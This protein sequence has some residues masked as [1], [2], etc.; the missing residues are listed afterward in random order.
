MEKIDG[1]SIVLNYVNGAFAAATTR[2]DGH[3]GEDQTE[4][5][6]HIVPNMLNTHESLRVRAEVTLTY[7]TFEALKKI[8]TETNHKNLRNSTVGLLNNKTVYPKKL[9]FL[10]VIGYEIIGSELTREQQLA[11]L[12]MLGFE[13]PE[14][15]AFSNENSTDTKTCLANFLKMQKNDAEYMI[16]GV[17][18][19]GEDYCGENAYYPDGM[20]AFKVRN[21][22]A[23]TTVKGIEWTISKGGLLKPVVLLEACEL[24]GTTVQRASGYNADNIS[25]LEITTGAKVT[26][27]KG[28]DII[29]VI[30]EVIAKGNHDCELPENCPSC[31]S[32]LE[33]TGDDGD[34]ADL[35]CRN[36]FCND[37]L[38]KQL[39]YFVRS[40]EMAGAGESNLSN[41]G[42]TSVADLIHV[43]R[44][45]CDYS[46]QEK[47]YNEL[48]EKAFKSSELELLG[49]MSWNGGGSRTITKLVNFY[50]TDKLSDFAHVG[51]KPTT[52]PDGLGLKTVTKM[53]EKWKENK[54]LVDEIMDDIRY[55]WSEP[56]VAK[57]TTSCLAGKSFCFT[58]KIS[59]PRKKYEQVVKDNGGEIK[60]VSK[61]LDFLVVGE[62]AG[63]KL[64][65]AEKAG[66]TIITEANFLANLEDGSDTSALD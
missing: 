8:D 44:P 21:D 42:I 56:I 27:Y 17:V 10:K 25:K 49:A 64:A 5:F 26:V 43:W 12:K 65:K 52:F 14:T 54:R 9:A 24:N 45:N 38:M 7:T 1:A 33:W 3:K 58:G 46:S 61:N 51:T 16:D 22:M 4:K 62:K 66:V 50:G 36:E 2:G 19:C 48:L 47:F 30:H 20:V 53:L 57:S 15:I 37:R 39:S 23:T 34:G 55:D 60:S 6:T 28:G 18:L 29:P 35:I 41:W 59:Q 40:M 31:T 32:K 13:I 11:K 63:G